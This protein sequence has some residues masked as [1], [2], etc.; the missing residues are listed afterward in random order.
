MSILFRL[1]TLLAATFFS[2]MQAQAAPST[3]MKWE[4][5]MIKPYGQVRPMPEAAAQLTPDRVYKVLF[6]IN[7]GAEQ[8]DKV[9]PALDRVARFINL[10][11]LAH[12]PAKHLKLVAVVHGKATPS[13]LADAPYRQKF[14]VANPNLELLSLLR[15]AGVEVYVC[16]QALAHQNIEPAA[17]AGDVTVAVSA[18]TVLA[19]YQLEGYALVP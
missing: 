5:P 2:T 9:V 18:L 7:Q 1:G 14:G 16:G 6:N 15:K 4:N 19:N 3:P 13:V 12:V 8:P 17:V 11:A 10:A